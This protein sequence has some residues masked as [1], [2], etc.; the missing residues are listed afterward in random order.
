MNK[1]FLILF[2]IPL[3][4][5]SQESK[6][7]KYDHPAYSIEYPENWILD[8]SGQEG[9]SFII[10][11]KMKSEK[12]FVENI[13]LVEQ[14]LGQN[15]LTIEQL[16]SLI[17]NQVSNMLN[18]PKIIVSEIINKNGFTYHYIRT[19]G[20]TNGMNF[21]TKIYT[22]PVKNNLF[23]LTLVSKA[24]DYEN[25]RVISSKIMDSFSIK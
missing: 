15:E 20:E 14:N 8:E 21:Q 23:T 1:I 11:P 9:S 22:Y 19:T 24:E 18:N 6:I 3:I 16:K 7:K 13:N 10:Y 17:E 25:I 2:L 12:D 4:V 5:L